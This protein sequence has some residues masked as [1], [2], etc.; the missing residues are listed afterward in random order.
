MAPAAGPGPGAGA[1]QPPFSHPGVG[2]GAA[3]PGSASLPLLRYLMLHGAPQLTEGELREVGDGGA[4]RGSR[5]TL[6][7]PDTDKA[8]LQSKQ[9][10]THRVTCWRLC[11]WLRVPMRACVT[12]GRWVGAGRVRGGGRDGGGG[13]GAELHTVE[14]A[15]RWRAVVCGV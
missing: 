3:A 8:I 15:L 2:V 11:T 14:A 12:L 1:R 13:E 4:G 7:V 6:D 5:G 9:G 10:S